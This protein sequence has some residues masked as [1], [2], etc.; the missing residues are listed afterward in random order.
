MVDRAVVGRG[1]YRRTAMKV[2]D[3]CLY[4]IS[5]EPEYQSALCIKHS[6]MVRLFHTC[7][8]WE[9]TSDEA[10]NMATITRQGAEE[11]IAAGYGL[12]G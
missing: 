5:I 12:S 9:G 7:K 8:D 2:C 6:E 11:I 4:A 10:R 1:D 3:T